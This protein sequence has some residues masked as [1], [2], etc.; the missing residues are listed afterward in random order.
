MILALHIHSPGDRFSDR[1]ERRF[2]F[3]SVNALLRIR[4]SKQILSKL[5]KT[6]AADFEAEEREE[7]LLFKDTC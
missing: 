4:K 5:A 6:I 3:F 1:Q 2:F 7:A